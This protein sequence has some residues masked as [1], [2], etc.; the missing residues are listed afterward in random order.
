MSGCHCESAAECHAGPSLSDS[1][2]AAHWHRGMPAGTRS[3]LLLYS[4]CHSSLLLLRLPVVVRRRSDS[5]S[6]ISLCHGAPARLSESESVR[7]GRAHKE[8]EAPWH[9]GRLLGR[10]DAVT[11]LEVG[12][13]AEQAMIPFS[14]RQSR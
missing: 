14:T 10:T 12:S 2:S 7:S 6:A 8:G 3:L 13:G 4:G 11:P 1:E 9:K 5:E